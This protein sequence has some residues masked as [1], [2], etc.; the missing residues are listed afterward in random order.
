LGYDA[1][2]VEYQNM[3]KELPYLEATS[4]LHGVPTQIPFGAKRSRTE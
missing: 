3:F 2:N 1:E 4:H